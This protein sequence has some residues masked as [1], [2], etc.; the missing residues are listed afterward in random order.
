MR[1][2]IPQNDGNDVSAYKGSP[3]S[4]LGALREEIK[5]NGIAQNDENDVSAT[6]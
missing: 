1:T 4:C 3:L 6:R 5:T 2:T